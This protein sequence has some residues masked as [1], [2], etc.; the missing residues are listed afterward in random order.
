VRAGFL[1]GTLGFLYLAIHL[2]G[3]AYVT[4]DY[5]MSVEYAE[6]AMWKK[7]ILLGFW[8]RIALYKYISCWLLT[9]GACIVMGKL[10]Y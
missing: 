1:R 7:L 3:A 9:E 8:G 4:D 5:I 10:K 6:A 2:I